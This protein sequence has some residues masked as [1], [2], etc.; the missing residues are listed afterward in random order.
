LVNV[1]DPEEHLAVFKAVCHETEKDVKA[2]GGQGGQG[3]QGVRVMLGDLAAALAVVSPCLLLEDLRDRLQRRYN[4]DFKKAFSDLDMDRS[5]KV[6][7]A[8]FVVRDHGSFAFD[9]ARGSEDVPR[10]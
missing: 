3:G 4:G 1:N 9:R 6:S 5:G 10:D 7:H 2:Q 8:E